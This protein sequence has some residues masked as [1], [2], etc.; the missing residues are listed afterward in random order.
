VTKG[1]TVGSSP[2][3]V[4]G[5]VSDE[6]VGQL[7]GLQTEYP[8]LDYKRVIDPATPRGRVELAKDVGAFQ[9]M[10]G[11]I[12]GGVDDH[13]ALTGEMDGVDASRFDEARLV[14]QLL[15]HLPQPLVLRSRVLQ[16][17]DHVIVLIFV[18]RHPSGYAIFHTD[19]QYQKDDGTMEIVFRAGDAY[20]RDGTRSVR[21]SQEG[22]ETIIEHRIAEAKGNWI[23]EQQE[24]RRREQAE[25]AAQYESRQVADAPL[26]SVNFDLD[27]TALTNSVLELI[28]RG[29]ER[30][31]MI[32]LLNDAAARARGAIE[33]DE[34][35]SELANLLDKLSCLAATFLVYEQEDWF[36]RIVETLAQIYSAPLGEHDAQRFGYST[37]IDPREKAPRVWL[38]IITRVFGLGALAVRRGDWQAVRTLTLQLPERLD[39]SY[40][41][42]WLR[43]AL[44]M[45]ARSDQLTEQVSLLS[46]AR[47]DVVRLACLRPDG[48][49][50]EDEAI[51]NS[52]AQFDVLS[53]ITAIGDAGDVD[54]R[55]FYPNFARFRQERATPIVSRL[56][57]SDEMRS[58]LFPRSDEDLAAALREI[59]RMAGQEGMRYAGFM[60][61]DRDVAT[62][63]RRHLPPET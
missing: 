20:W 3:V 26:G 16:W 30:V 18:G 41:T 2:V 34:I 40:D 7:L 51:L 32:R 25:L 42:N 14:P 37:R 38:Q 44:T 29:N 54:S 23:E 47:A 62:F 39:A 56:L 63:I 50:E 11:Y 46:L 21:I 53:N 31:P 35:E 57:T 22:M 19:G 61:W 24:I 48:L 49:S 27:T 45:G 1:L 36:N 28:H 8:E 4:D 55:V 60:G 58:V 43:H 52:L 33:R 15:R 13:G 5:I 6:K 59:G 17:S 10:G 12:I 9:V